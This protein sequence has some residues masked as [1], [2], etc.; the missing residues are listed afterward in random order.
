MAWLSGRNETACFLV[1]RHSTHVHTMD[2]HSH[3]KNA[4]NPQVLGSLL[5]LLEVATEGDLGVPVNPCSFSFTLGRAECRVKAVH[6]AKRKTS[7]HFSHPIK[8]TEL[9]SEDINF[10]VFLVGGLPEVYTYS[11]GVSWIFLR[12]S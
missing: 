7:C 3:D 1:I 9:W 12:C 10:A 5:L 2:L 6:K 8:A 4:D 11:L